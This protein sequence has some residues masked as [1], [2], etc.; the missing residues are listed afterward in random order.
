M[1]TEISAYAKINLFLDVVGIREDGY[2]DVENVMQSISLFDTV[3]VELL[4]DERIIIECDKEGVPLGDKNIAH[5]A[6]RLFFDRAN[7]KK[8]ARIKIK[9]NIPMAAGLAGGSADGAAVLVG[10]NELCNNTFSKEELCKMGAILGADVPFCIVCGSMYSDGR[11]D[12]LREFPSISENTCFVIACGGEG[13]STPWAYGMLDKDYN[14][15]IGYEKKGTQLL[16]KAIVA[17]DD[18]F[19]DELFNLFEATVSRER[20]VVSEIK[21]IMETHGAKRAMMSGSGPSVFGVFKDAQSAET[22]SKKI[23]EKGYFSCVA[24]PIFERKQV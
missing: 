21:E 5:K 16:Y 4:D 23:L 20:P 10:L 14:N 11:G 6:A 15:F 18:A 9:K 8:G 24:Y 22:A 2:H 17:G 1:K 19:C 12:N 13:V 7:I 3:E